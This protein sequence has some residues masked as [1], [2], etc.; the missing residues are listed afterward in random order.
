M[1]FFG[2][3]RKNGKKT[4]FINFGQ[5]SRDKCVDKSSDNIAFIFTQVQKTKE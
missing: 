2:Q 3:E 4:F 1:L 5:T